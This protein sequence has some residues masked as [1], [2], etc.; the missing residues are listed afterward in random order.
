M[1]GE[2][3]ELW[4]HRTETG[5]QLKSSDGI[6]GDLVLKQ[7]HQSIVITEIT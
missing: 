2:N 4:Q 3:E 1:R 7:Y 6:S 5:Y